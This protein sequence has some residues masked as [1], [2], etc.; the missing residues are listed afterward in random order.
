MPSSNLPCA[1]SSAAFAFKEMRW[2]GSAANVRVSSASARCRRCSF[3]GFVVTVEDF[4]HEGGGDAGQSIDVVRLDLQRPLV[5]F[6][7]ADHRRRRRGSIGDRLAAH[8]EVDGLRAFRPLALA[9]PGFDVDHLQAD[10]PRQATDD[11]VLH[12]QDIG[13][14][15][16]EPFGPKLA[17]GAGIVELGVDADPFSVGKD[18][19]VST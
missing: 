9:A 1:R 10:R 6:A 13:S 8:D 12:L 7:R 17:A 14:L 18:A 15:D 3:A 16:V 2:R 4:E 5:E 11:L 19:A